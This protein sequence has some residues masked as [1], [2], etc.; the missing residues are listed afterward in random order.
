MAAIIVVARLKNRRNRKVNVQ[1]YRRGLHRPRDTQGIFVTRQPSSLS[2]LTARLLAGVIATGMATVPQIT[3][4]QA[5]SAQDAAAKMRAN[6]EKLEEAERKAKTLQA[7]VAQIDG[8]RNRLNAQLQE[9][10]KLV[11]RSE[12]QMTTIESRRDGLEGEQK[13]LEAVL[14]ER[15]ESIGKLLGAMQRMG[16]NPPPVIITRREDALQMVRSAASMRTSR[17]V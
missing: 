10:A 12:A 15:Q 7:D 9:T 17:G 6:R 16:R 1:T 11:Q 3:A 5:P 4:A 8:E 2:A 13:A 14:A